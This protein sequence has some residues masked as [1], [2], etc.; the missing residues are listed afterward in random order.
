[1]WVAVEQLLIERGILPTEDQPEPKQDIKEI[2]LAEYSKGNIVVSTFEGNLQ[3]MPL[4]EF[5]KQSADG[6][7]YDLNRT[8]S[9]SLT[10]MHDPKWVNDF[11]VAKV[12]KELKNQVTTK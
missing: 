11:A 3:T 1:D 5:I 7:L 4:T 6:I 8:E 2:V 9:V 10:F 12:I